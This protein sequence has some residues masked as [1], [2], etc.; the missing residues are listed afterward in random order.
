ML[1]FYDIAFGIRRGFRCRRKPAVIGLYWFVPL[2][3]VWLKLQPEQ[4]GRL[5]E[6]TA[7]SPLKCGVLEGK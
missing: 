6:W 7:I 5:I 4:A 3:P 1:N 2:K